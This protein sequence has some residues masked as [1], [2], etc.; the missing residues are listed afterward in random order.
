MA[1]RDGWPY[2]TNRMHFQKSFKVGGGG[3]FWTLRQGFLSMKFE[4][5]MQHDFLKIH[6][7][8]CGHPSLSDACRPLCSIHVEPMKS[9]KIGPNIGFVPKLILN[10]AILQPA[11]LDPARRAPLI[12]TEQNL[13][14]IRTYNKKRSK[15][16]DIMNQAV[17]MLRGNQAETSRCGSC[18]TSK[19]V[20]TT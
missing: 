18:P 3:R 19:A 5:K 11:H 9:T 14:H 6:L 20:R 8:Y 10:L 17:K 16:R 13:F 4:E 12:E 7:F 2:L 15:G 1:V